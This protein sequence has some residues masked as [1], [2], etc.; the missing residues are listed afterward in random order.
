M[1]PARA[2][3][4]TARRLR[5]AEDRAIAAETALADLRRQL[6]EASDPT[7]LRDECCIPLGADAEPLE[8]TFLRLQLRHHR[9]TVSMLH[10]I[11]APEPDI[12]ANALGCMAFAPVLEEAHGTFQIHPGPRWP[13]SSWR[14][15]IAQRCG[16]SNPDHSP[17]GW[18]ETA[19]RGAHHGLHVTDM[20]CVRVDLAAATARLHQRFAV[21]GWPLD[22][23]DADQPVRVHPSPLAWLR[24]GCD[25]VV[26]VG[27]D[28][29]NH[30]WLRNC[31]AGFITDTIEMGQALET[32]LRRDPVRMPPIMVRKAA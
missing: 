8:A 19:R 5:A 3:D 27:D 10:R 14:W 16:A 12:I 29:D 15:I 26:L 7:N 2:T 9:E 32:K 18:P 31:T 28:R 25:G 21:L 20:I 22:P 17:A 13:K 1:T 30:A 6:A 4:D 23:R 11:F 24:S